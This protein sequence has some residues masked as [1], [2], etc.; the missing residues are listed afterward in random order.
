MSILERKPSINLKS[1]RSDDYYNFRLRDT[2]ISLGYTLKRL[3]KKSGV[4]W[5][6]LHAYERLRAF[7][8]E[9]PAQRISVVL[10][11]PIE[12]LFPEY[13]IQFTKELRKERSSQLE[14]SMTI[15][16]IDDIP[17]GASPIVHDTKME[18]IIQEEMKQKLYTTLK[19]L[20]FREREIILLRYGLS[21][22]E[23]CYST[24]EVGRIFKICPRRVWQIER[25]VMQKLRFRLS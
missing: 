6:T 5:V 10:G 19:N 4:K 25:K 23:N 8:S 15:V 7:P 21:D 20:K 22:Y 24:E 1:D 14:S 16:S 2:R 12:Y 11:K 17:E 18:Q 13:L 3:A 9:E